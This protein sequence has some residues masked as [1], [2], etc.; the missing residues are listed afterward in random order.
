MTMSITDLCLL[1]DDMDR[2]ITFYRDAMGLKVKRLDTGFAEFHAG[3]TT[4]A[5]WLRNDIAANLDAPGLRK[6]GTGIMA[7]V[8][9]ADPEAVDAEVA[10]L[11][12]SG[13]TM[14]HAPQAWP[15]NAYA[16]YFNDPDDHLWEIYSW[17]GA[18]RT[19]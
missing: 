12:G 15:W 6:P 14:S 13:I 5:L 9:L 8:R 2:S 17:M 16:A 4:L 7:A 10:R 18:P 19:L 1:V 11:E 3:P